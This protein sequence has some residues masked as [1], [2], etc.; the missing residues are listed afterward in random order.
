MPFLSFFHIFISCLKLRDNNMENFFFL[1]SFLYIIWYF[2]FF[3]H[4][5]D[6][7]C[8]IFVWNKKMY[9]R[10]QNWSELGMMYRCYRG[11][12]SIRTESQTITIKWYNM[13][14]IKAYFMP[15]IFEKC[16]HDYWQPAHSWRWEH[17]ND[18][19]EDDYNDDK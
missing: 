4:E 14:R 8:E 12:S 6:W 13:T 16:S 17:D 7:K 10:K 9:K 15:L 11:Q 5:Y 3:P 18:K 2:S 19:D 1:L